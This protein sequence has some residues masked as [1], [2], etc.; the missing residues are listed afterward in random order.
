MLTNETSTHVAL[1]KNIYF[2]NITNSRIA[3][4]NQYD[5]ASLNVVN[6]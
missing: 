6:I 3:K 4:P 5:Y 2:I 1:H